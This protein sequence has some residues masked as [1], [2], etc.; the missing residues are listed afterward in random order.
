MSQSIKKSIIQS[1]LGSWFLV[2]GAWVLGPIVFLIH[3]ARIWGC[4]REGSRATFLLLFRPGRPSNFVLKSLLFLIPFLFDF[5]SIVGAK[6][7]PKIHKNPQKD[8]FAIAP[9]FESIF[10]PIFN[11]F[12][13]DF[14]PPAKV[15]T[16]LKPWSIVRFYTF[17]I[18]VL[19]FLL[20]SILDHL[21]LHFGVVLAPFF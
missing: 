11:D 6:M 7:T 9:H 20:D 13:F 10:E 19:S 21:G 16:R 17:P 12:S 3:R 1:T 8:V 4:A 14:L 15:K 5:G 2:F 18:F